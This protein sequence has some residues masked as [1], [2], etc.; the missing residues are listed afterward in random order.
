MMEYKYK[1]DVA[2]IKDQSFGMHKSHY[3]MYEL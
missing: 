1:I 2:D 3:L